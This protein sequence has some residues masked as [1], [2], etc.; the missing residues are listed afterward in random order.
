M[1]DSFTALGG[2][3]P[4][5]N[6]ELGEIIVGGV[7]AGL[8]GI[9]AVRGAG[10][11][12]GRSDGRP[13]A[14]ISRQ[15][16]RGEARS[17]WRCSPSSSCRLLMLGFTAIATV[18]P[19]AV[20]SAW[21]I[22]GPH[23]FSEILYAYVSAA[24]EQRLGLRRPHGQH[25]LVQHHLGISMLVGRFLMIVPADGHRRLP[26]RQEDSACLGR[27]R[28]RPRAALRRPRSSASS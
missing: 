6:M 20:A 24:S 25:A 2:M 21:P 28:S 11:L 7:G 15:E 16:D 18:L 10:D 26:R 4:S 12:R 3:I 22:A 19:A 17:R 13:H 8:Y 5:I 27:A 9:A 1:H 23:G 14:G